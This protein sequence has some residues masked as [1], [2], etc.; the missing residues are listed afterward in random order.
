M[1]I[2]VGHFQCA[3]QAGDYEANLRTVLRGLEMATAEKIEILSF[4]ES[5]LT[6][7]FDGE[8]RTR[9]HAWRLD[10]A[11]IENVLARTKAFPLMFMVGF[12][13][14]RG[15]ELYNTVLLAEK[16]RVIGHYSKAFP[17]LDFFTP[18]REFPV[19]EK[20]GV[21]FG[22]IICADGGYIEPCRIL[23]LKGARLI[24]APHYNYIGAET[25]LGHYECVR[26]DHAARAVENGVWFLRA[27]NI[28]VGQDGGLRREG[29][30]YG[31]SYLLD[32]SGQFVARAGLQCE[33]L[34]AA[35]V[36]LD[37]D[38][39]GGRGKSNRRS[40][41][42]LGPLVRAALETSG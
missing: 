10:Q 19:F 15:N 14:L 24:F 28:V 13:E 5:F 42:E 11:E 20:N 8:D 25:L 31:D 16:G 1:P 33:T 38:H 29:I 41:R 30:G 7:Y 40:A 12:N 32:P 39:Y 34:M 23:A 2:K 35:V 18:G 4:P 37:R 17:C 36:D 21:K 6:G 22:I 9:K 3:C 27:N 26:H